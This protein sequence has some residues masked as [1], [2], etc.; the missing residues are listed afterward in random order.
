MFG[1]DRKLWLIASASFFII[2]LSSCSILKRNRVTNTRGLQTNDF[3]LPVVV[4]PSS[5]PASKRLVIMLSG[6]GGWLDFND[7]L[8][9]AFSKHGFN[10]IGFNSRTYFWEQRSPEQTASD[11][12]LLIDQYTKLYKTS[13]IYLVGYSFGADVV[14]FLYN[15][16]PATV[17]NKVVALE[18]LSPFASSDFM[19]HT[20]DLLNI[21]ADDKPFKVAEEL[22]S[23]SIPIFCFYGEKED[24]KALQKVKKRNFIIRLVAGDHH[25]E[26]SSVEKIVN[27]MR[28]L[29]LIRL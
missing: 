19:V 17:R 18:M 16:L 23:V 26:G 20:A 8:A 1:L 11:I 6:D 2:T 9:V 13:R 28:S 7:E 12:L 15:R 14:P 25:Y 3:D 24:P 4:Y 5:N 21:S 10:V 22:Q 29:R 27:A